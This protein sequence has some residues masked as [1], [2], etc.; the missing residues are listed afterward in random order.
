M[1]SNAIKIISWTP[2]WQRLCVIALQRTLMPLVSWFIGRVSGGLRNDL[3][4]LFL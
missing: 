4:S 2:S 3:I 1:P